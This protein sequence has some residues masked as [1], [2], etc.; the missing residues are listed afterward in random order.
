MRN[1]GKFLL[2]GAIRP[3]EIARIKLPCCSLTP[4]TDLVVER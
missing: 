2:G 4:L 3:K 1:A